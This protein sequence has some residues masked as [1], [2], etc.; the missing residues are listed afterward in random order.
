MKQRSEM[1]S[2]YAYN[3]FRKYLADIFRSQVRSLVHKDE[4]RADRVVQL[5]LVL[6]NLSNREN[7]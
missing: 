4:E 7:S 6:T 1:P 2:I 3:D 5:A